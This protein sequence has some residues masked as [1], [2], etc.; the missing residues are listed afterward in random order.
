MK[1]F[2]TVLKKELTRFFKDRK[3]IFTMIFPGILIYILYSVIGGAMGSIVDSTGEQVFSILTVNRSVEIEKLAEKEFAY[4]DVEV[5]F[6]LSELDETESKDLVKNG[7]FDALIV[8]PENFDELVS[9]ENETVPHVSVFYNSNETT[10]AVAYEL[11]IALL[12]EFETK[13]V[14][15]FDVNTS[16]NKYDLADASDIMGQVYSMIVPMLLM[17]FAVTGAVSVTPESVA[18]EKERGTIATILVTPVKRWQIALGKICSL[19]V[20]S[21]IAM[22]SSFFGTMF[23]LPNLMGAVGDMVEIETN[24]FVIFD[25]SKII[26][27]LFVLMT[28][29]PLIVGI[30]SILSTLSK[31][32]KEATSISSVLMLI[33]F[34]LLGLSSMIGFG[35]PLW[36]AFVPFLNVAVAISGVLTASV[37]TLFLILAIVANVVYTG[38]I[39]ALLAKLFGSEKIML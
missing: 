39:V 26:A 18:G 29:I 30:L 13:L 4:G 5:E 7:L 15:R 27:L 3:L 34:M 11:I 28:Y 37:S 6:V 1:G 23:S 33:V 10:S 12:D 38:L 25:A 9:T 32:V 22:L 8:F 24:I 14:N 36:M 31:S 19:S 21:M 35:T 2:L 20:E 17:M 16:F